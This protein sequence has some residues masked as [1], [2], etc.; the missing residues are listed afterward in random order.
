MHEIITVTLLEYDKEKHEFVGNYNG[1]EIR[2]DPF[3][4]CLWSD[5]K[6]DTGTFTFVGHWHKRCFIPVSE[7][8]T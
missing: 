4:S 3:V 5:E 1:S 6:E 8:T 2:V 7:V